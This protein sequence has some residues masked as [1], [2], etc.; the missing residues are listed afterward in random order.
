MSKKLTQKHLKEALDYN[1][2]T[3]IFIWLE[4][5]REYF[6][7]EESSKTWNTRF[8][9]KVAGYKDKRGYL[10][11]CVNGKK[12][13][14]H[15]LAFLYMTG[16]F[17]ENDTDHI[18]QK[19]SDNQW[20]NLRGVTNQENHKNLGMYPNNASGFTGVSFCK[21]NNKWETYIYAK[22]KRKYLGY[23][24]NINDAI[25]ARKAANI[26]YGY[27]ANHGVSI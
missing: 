13:W 9:G 2:E 14:A 6:P 10:Q 24:T 17:P 11:I 4:R 5:D 15:R 25:E 21:G 18:N 16:D 3:G 22:G 27:H 12:Y 23:F 26:E 8:S 7:T 19:K 1:P 20:K